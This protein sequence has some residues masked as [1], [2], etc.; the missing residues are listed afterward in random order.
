MV[1]PHLPSHDDR[2][3]LKSVHLC[4]L[5]LTLSV[6]AAAPG[7]A[8]L[9]CAASARAGTDA[10]TQ[11]E[12]LYNRAR[13][14][15]EEGLSARRC[16]EGLEAKHPEQPWFLFYLGSLHWADSDRAQELYRRA[17][18]R[19][20]AMGDLE[21]EVKARTARSTL[22]LRQSRG[23]E[24]GREVQR[25]YRIAGASNDP[26]LAA[27]GRVALARYLV[28]TSDD[29][30]RVRRLLEDSAGEGEPCAE[31]SYGPRRDCLIILGNVDSDQGRFDEARRAFRRLLAE[32]LR[33]GDAYAEATARYGLTRVAVER[34]VEV[35]D[36]DR[37]EAVIRLA[38]GTLS[39][40]VRTHN[41]GIQAKASWI[42]GALIRGSA[43]Q[44]HLMQCQETAPSDRDKSYCLSALARRRSKSDP[45]EA[46]R[47]MNRAV[48][49]ARQAEDPFSQ[50]F[51]ERE[52]MR[53]AWTLEGPV[54]ATAD[55]WAALDAIEKLRD[56][57]PE[58][59]AVQ[60]GLFSTW[61]DDYLWLSGRL[62]RAASK[63][64]VEAGW[65][66]ARAFEVTERMRARSLA[67]ALRASKVE[68]EGPPPEIGASFA[69]LKAVRRGLAP[70][71]ALLSFQVAP[72][73]D[74]SG[75]FGGGSWLLAV[76]RSGVRV[77]PLPD[78][79]ELR[80][81]VAF[82]DGL[83]TG[84][85][86]REET[87]AALAARLYGR[88]LAPAIA[89]LPP[90][91]TRLVLLPDDALHRLPFDALRAGATEPPLGAR[92]ALSRAPSA[93]LWLHWRGEKP[94]KT[95][96]AALVLADPASPPAAAKLA[97]APLAHA[98]SE[99]WEVAHALRRGSSLLE[100][101]EASEAALEGPRLADFAVLHLAAHAV[102]DEAH[103]ERSAVVLAAGGAVGGPPGSGGADGMLRASEIA[104]LRLD[105][106]LVVLGSCR[107]AGGQVLRGEGVMSLAR[108]FFQAGAQTVVATLWPVRDDDAEVL[109]ERFYSHLARGETVAEALREA[110]R[111]RI[112]A[113]APATAWAGFVVLG[114][115]D[116][117]PV[118]AGAGRLAWRLAAI[119]IAAG[120]L[121]L[122][123]AALVA[124]RLGR[125]VLRRRRDPVFH[126]NR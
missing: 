53:M 88:L 96:R 72:S 2:S 25:V 21:G 109:F 3:W 70:D 68:P 29:L 120:C 55:S 10:K 50:A 116:A 1:G 117:R 105:G 118:P 94:P 104:R 14:S 38:R 45:A 41:A 98:R 77:Y 87:E 57:Q 37:R 69:T 82:F 121:L 35:P 122:V 23:E 78:R 100:G 47:L 81:A 8:A 126:T 90:T 63:G 79:G 74:L 24:A 4:C 111:E 91:V 76:T 22:L 75:D 27:Q 113:G 124:R 48:A 85:P 13:L 46:E 17:A 103:P 5:L 20:E 99:G 110:R 28:Q 101:D 32:T 43:G 6:A 97:L 19:F 95:L 59:S 54:Q 119:W 56:L 16:L 102:T 58:G 18:L 30:D 106:R 86:G 71:Q 39:A 65:A 9:P 62:L 108:A 84:P 34:L 83:F 125:G 44:P 36:S 123:L 7:E 93:T 51:A 89:D 49:L 33:A 40:A 73:E 15:G 80:N 67:D 12:L 66:E 114:D 60:A 42:L 115:G 107:S 31:G 112:A 64:H 61:A 26:D 11:G 52:R 92:F